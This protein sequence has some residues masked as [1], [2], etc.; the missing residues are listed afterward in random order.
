MNFDLFGRETEKKKERPPISKLEWEQVKKRY[1]N[2]CCLCGKSE[3]SVGTLEKAHI[4][5][6]SRGG[7]QVSPM[8]PNC[9]NKFDNGLLNASELKK[10]GLTKAQYERLRPKPP[11]DRY[12][13][14]A[15]PI[16]GKI[17]VLKED[18]EVVTDMYGKK[19]RVIKPEAFMS[20]RWKK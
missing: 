14:V 16:H 18:T 13:T 15:H 4:K 6:F 19:V 5:A 12:L 9:H 7:T 11:K 20:G 17:K 8:C 10:L 2:K 3:K 1:G